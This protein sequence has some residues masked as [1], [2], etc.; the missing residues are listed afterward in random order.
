ML[1]GG[2]PSPKSHS[3]ETILLPGTGVDKLVNVTGCPGQ[4]EP[5]PIPGA[6][7]NGTGDGLIVILNDDVPQVFVIVIVAVCGVGL[8][9]GVNAGIFPV[10]LAGIPIAGLL[11]VHVLPTGKLKGPTV[12]PFPPHSTI[13][14]KVGG[15]GIIINPVEA[16]YIP[17]PSSVKTVFPDIIS[18]VIG[19][20]VGIPGKSKFT[21]S[22]YVFA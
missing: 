14:G 1:T 10:P 20:L 11:F 8:F 13:S 6:E 19:V 9:V 18:I 7:K 16:G 12:F 5:P 4:T 17:Q 21:Q 2:E 22:L 15:G 3:Y